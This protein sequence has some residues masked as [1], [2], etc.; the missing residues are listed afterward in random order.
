MKS[1]IRVSNYLMSLLTLILL[2][3]ICNT[4]TAQKNQKKLRIG[5]FDSRVITIAYTRSE[6][7]SNRMSEMQ[8]EGEAD[9]QGSDSTRKVEAAYKMITFQYRLHQQGFCTGSV[10]SI[11]EI[12]KEKLPEVAKDAGVIAILSKWELSYEDPSIEIVDLTMP[13]ANLFNPKGDFEKI[14]QEM[15]NEAPVPLEEFTVE[16]VIQMWKQFESR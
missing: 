3:F 13:I 15:G 14:A 1:T 12:I 8:K 2:L 6:A 16:E 5:T 9:L 10:S 4:V 7:F 11:I